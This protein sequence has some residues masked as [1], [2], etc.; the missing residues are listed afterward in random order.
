M[1]AR[2]L[3]LPAVLLAVAGLPLIPG[4]CTEE[5][6]PCLVGIPA[7]RIEGR[8]LTGGLAVTAVIRA[9]GVAGGEASGSTI[10]HDVEPDGRFGLDL[11]AGRYVVA[12]RIGP[13]DATYDYTAGGPGYGNVAP[14]TLRVDAAVSPVVADFALGGF[15]LDLPLSDRPEG[16]E[17]AIRLHRRDTAP[18]ASLPRYLDDGSAPVQDGRATLTLAG[19]LPGEYQVEIVLVSR[20]SSGGEH[21]WLPGTRDRSDAPWYAVGVDEAVPLACEL[22]GDP[23]RLEGRIAGAW[24]A[25][26][27]P[28]EPELFIVGPDSGLVMDR[29]R[30]ESDGSFAVD[31][32]LPGPVKLGVEQYGAVQWIGGP[33]FVEA[34]T[35]DLRAGETIT[36]IE[37]VQS[38]LRLDIRAPTA[39]SGWAAFELHDPVDLSLMATVV[40]DIAGHDVVGIPNLWP[41]DF[42]LHV[43]HR[44]P[45]EYGVSYRSPPWRPQWYDRAG[46]PAQAVPI[47]IAAAGEVVTRE[48]T[49]ELGGAI[50]GRLET[51]PL[52]PRGF[53]VFLSPAD[54]DTVLD[55]WYVWYQA[56][57]FDLAGLPDGDYKVGAC[58]TSVPWIWGLPPPAG[59]VWYPD[60]TIWD[61]AAVLEI[62]DA[63]EVEGVVIPVP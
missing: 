24:L 21:F 3:L 2:R 30:V 12:L 17:V 27:L 55:A 56:P 47:T 54:V 15:T 11:P 57:D 50:R 60:T 22:G 35:Y 46:A 5:G 29:R 28:E 38:G 61:E 20:S 36:G 59:T 53:H 62:R 45:D 37:L 14:D 48:L 31:L 19:V 39:S 25:M 49:L 32:S 42:L 8:V 1:S 44:G 18:V 33:T 41:G 40:V 26:G 9:T 23:S 34:A 43:A 10:E 63:C 51:A 7:G 58:P 4:G 6:S 52:P 16:E 13:Y